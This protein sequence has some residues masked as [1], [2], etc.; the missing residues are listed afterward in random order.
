MT[1][2]ADSLAPELAVSEV[3]ALMGGELIARPHLS[4][5]RVLLG[6]ASPYELLVTVDGSAIPPH[7]DA[8]QR[9]L[10]IAS[11]RRIPA[12]YASLAESCALVG[13]QTAGTLVICD[14]YDREKQHYLTH[15]AMLS[16]CERLQLPRPSKVHLGQPSSERELRRLLESHRALGSEI[17]LRQ[18]EDGVLRRWAMVNLHSDATRHF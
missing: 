13:V 14:L 2:L 18:E 3:S 1:T 12:L 15:E 5:S 9:Q 11:W 6:F 4:G 8:S 17:E 10:L 16:R 7:P